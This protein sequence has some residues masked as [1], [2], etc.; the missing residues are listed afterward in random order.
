MSQVRLVNECPWFRSVK[1]CGLTTTSVARQTPGGSRTRVI[2]WFLV[3]QEVDA[4][5]INEMGGNGRGGERR[6][7]INF[8]QPR[9]WCENA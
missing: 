5:Q 2:F 7:H 9:Y 3:F 4:L 1:G 6:L 8:H